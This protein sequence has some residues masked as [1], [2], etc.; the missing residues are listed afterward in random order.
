MARRATRSLRR[1][2]RIM[3]NREYPPQWLAYHVLLGTVE[4]DGV[5]EVLGYATFAEYMEA[6]VTGWTG[7][8]P[9][10]RR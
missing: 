9:W 1:A 6:E 7:R 3:R 5:H 8:W 10:S 2:T 4:K